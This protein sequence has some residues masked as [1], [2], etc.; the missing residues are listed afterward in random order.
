MGEAAPP[1]LKVLEAVGWRGSHCV[2]TRDL[3]SRSLVL[4]EAPLVTTRDDVPPGLPSEEVE[5]ILVHALLTA[6]K[7]QSWA[8]SYLGDASEEGG[9]AI[10]PPDHDA[11]LVAWLCQTHDGLR[12]R[13]AEVTALYSAVTRH[14]FGLET[15]LL[16]IEYGAAFYEQACRLNH[17]CDP[18]CLSMR[19]GGNM[20]IFTC[21]DVG[22]GEELTHSYLPARLL[23]LPLRTRSAHLNFRCRCERCA[24]EPPEPPPATSAAGFPPG[25]ATTASGADLARFKVLCAAGDHGEVLRQGQKLLVAELAELKA[26]PIAALEVALPY[27][28]AFWSARATLGPELEQALPGCDALPLASGLAAAAAARLEVE[29]ASALRPHVPLAHLALLRQRT[30]VMSYLL[31]GSPRLPALPRLL[32]ALRGLEAA[33]EGAG[34][35][36]LWLRDD[37]AFIDAHMA[38]ALKMGA[39]EGAATAHQIGALEGGR[40][41]EELGGDGCSRRGCQS[42]EKGEAPFSRCS[43]C[44][45]AKYCSAG[46]QRQDWGLHKRVCPHLAQ[47]VGVRAR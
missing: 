12:G 4:L 31:G 6:G 7:R 34:E 24:A 23:L 14:A 1:A 46:C 18:N 16:A 3:P 42:V 32:A 33:T 20:A 26:R 22:A 27:L 30:A 45:V 38:A 40:A 35:A 8:K 36:C 28:S 15:P 29:L 25:H 10:P 17:S 37:T 47:A 41:P 9:S 39:L 43:V 5:W 11:A 19:L 21:K 2:A 44:K 13:E